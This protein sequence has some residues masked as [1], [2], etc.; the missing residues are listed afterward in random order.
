[1]FKV[2][3]SLPIILFAV[4]LQFI[5]ATQP[6]LEINTETAFIEVDYQQSIYIVNG[7]EIKKYSAAGNFLF[8]YSDKINGEISVLDVSN[9][10]RILLFYKESN[11]VV[12]LNQQLAPISEPVDIFQ[13]ANVEVSIVA[14]SAENG[15]W[16]LV[17]NK[18]ALVY[19]N[20]QMAAKKES[21]NL[22]AW[23]QDERIRFLKEHEQ[24]IYLGLSSKVLVFD[25]FGL[26][27]TT[28][29]LKN[30]DEFYI[31][32]NNIC[33]LRNDGIIEYNLEFKRETKYPIGKIDEGSQAFCDKN[34]IY[35]FSKE[36]VN[37]YKKRM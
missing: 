4:L 30:I 27:L 11:K 21:Q 20:E 3:Y 32:A 17:E 16:A 15:F 31:V 37:V 28:V 2:R 8:R 18:Q 26:Y 9:P 7:S 22:T 36:S 29:H 1:M 10:L 14:A 6:L 25:L 33:Y 34:R 19:F 24:K 35:I 13:I 5:G 23:I 12:F